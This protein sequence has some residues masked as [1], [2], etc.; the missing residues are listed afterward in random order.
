MALAWPLPLDKF[1]DD[2]PIARFT[3]RPGDAST[4]SET[5]GG[6]VIKH[7]HGS[8][9]WAG[10]IVLDKDY[11][12]VLAA[13]EARL[14][15]LEEPGASFLL[16]DPRQPDPIADPGKVILGGA[17]PVI[18]SLTANN[19]ELKLS[20]LPAG[21]VVSRGDLL[22]FT[23]GDNPA[24]YAYHRVATGKTADGSGVTGN[25]EVTPFIRPGAETGAAVTLGNPV[26][27]A[28]LTTSQYGEGR[29]KVSDGL[30]FN[31]QQ[32]LR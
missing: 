32:T 27:K 29:S 22:G 11:H 28:V 2:L 30:S 13:I 3:A 12:H 1:F 25:I 10:R 18:E 6:E 31:W 26:L 16:T 15:L 7:R 17:S 24:R 5:Y 8:R 4:L 20:G 19:R 9:L 21:Y 14:A 23:Y